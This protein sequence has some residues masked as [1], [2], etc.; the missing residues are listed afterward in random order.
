MTMTALE[1]LEEQHREVDDTIA[2]ILEADEPDEKQR[3]FDKLADS[4]AAHSTIEEKRFYPAVRNEQT[5]DLIKESYD[6]HAEIKELL[7][8]MMDLD[9]ED[10]EFEDQL[11]ALQEKIT[12]HAHE[13]EEGELFPRVLKSIALAELEELGKQLRELYETEMLSE[14]R[15][16]LPQPAEEQPGVEAEAPP[17]PSR[18]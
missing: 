15:M 6:E 3:L 18:S 7:A 14:P 17:P 9:I 16:R 4:L 13:E 11:A 12:K 5:E 8:E 1:L 10:D 2:R